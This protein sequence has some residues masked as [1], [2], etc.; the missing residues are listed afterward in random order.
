MKTERS[1]KLKKNRLKYGLKRSLNVK[2]MKLSVSRRGSL[3]LVVPKKASDS[4]I[5][6]FII[7]RADWIWD[8]LDVIIR[9]NQG[10]A[11]KSSRCDYLKNRERARKFIT[12]RVRY[13]SE[14]HGF[15]YN[16]IRIKNQ[17][18]VW[19]SCSVDGNLNFNYILF[20]MPKDIADYIIIHELCHLKRFDHSENFWNLVARI[21][22]G[23]RS[24]KQ[25]S[26][27]IAFV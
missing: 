26:D 18:T 19:G 13:F 6:R 4:A 20:K 25:K 24:I 14:M 15:K 22:P 17:R 12:D 5:R 8:R 3:V 10:K 16:K 9:I 1:I 23:Y 21:L 2:E 11:V 7:S 27:E